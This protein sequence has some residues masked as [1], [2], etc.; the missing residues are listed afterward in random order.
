MD[1]LMI[2]PACPRIAF[3]FR[4]LG[5]EGNPYRRRGEG[6]VEELTA[7]LWKAMGGGPAKAAAR[8]ALKW[9]RDK[10]QQ[11]GAA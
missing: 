2:Q 4:E 7:E 10:Q 8:A 11:G 1:D 6:S 5:L 3:Y 9:M